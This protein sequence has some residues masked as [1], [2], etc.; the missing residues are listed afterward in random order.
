MQVYCVRSDRSCEVKFM[1]EICVYCKNQSFLA[2]AGLLSA[3]RPGGA[4][5]VYSASR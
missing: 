5:V 2:Y 4:G 3:S 1:Q